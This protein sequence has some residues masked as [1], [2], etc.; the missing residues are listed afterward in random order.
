MGWQ[1]PKLRGQLQGDHDPDNGRQ[2]VHQQSPNNQ[3]RSNKLTSCLA[4]C[5]SIEPSRRQLPKRQVNPAEPETSDRGYCKDGSSVVRPG[6]RSHAERSQH[7]RRKQ[8]TQKRIHGKPT[9]KDELGQSRSTLAVKGAV[10]R[11]AIERARKLTPPPARV[12]P[13]PQTRTRYLPR[14]AGRGRPPRAPRR[15]H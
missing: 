9:A 3:T 4:P 5:F 15:P 11:L 8:E 7:G 6:S 1:P 12:P 10:S 14:P 2:N 13:R